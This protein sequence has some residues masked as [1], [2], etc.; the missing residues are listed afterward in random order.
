MLLSAGIALHIYVEDGYEVPY[1]VV[2]SVLF[3]LIAPGV[4]LTGLIIYDKLTSPSFRTI[5]ITTDT[6][7]DLTP[8]ACW[9]TAPIS[10]GAV[11][12]PIVL[13]LVALSI[14]LHRLRIVLDKDEDGENDMT[15]ALINGTLI[16]ALLVSVTWVIGTLGLASDDLLLQYLFVAFNAVQG[17]VICFFLCVY[18]TTLCASLFSN[19]QTKKQ[20][21]MADPELDV[22]DPRNYADYDSQASNQGIQDIDFTSSSSSESGPSKD[23]SYM[24]GSYVYGGGKI[25]LLGKCLLKCNIL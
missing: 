23:G 21:I 13:C 5:F 20:E 18:S 11:I 8:I 1:F 25:G 24:D 10:Y 6:T 16:I 17:I 4:I 9:I 7:T 14:C 3:S 15:L 19:I 2:K 22:V 12:F